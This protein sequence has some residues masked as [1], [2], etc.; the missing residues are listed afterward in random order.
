MQTGANNR[1][2][3][4][5]IAAFLLAV[6][7]TGVLLMGV[8]ASPADTVLSL[9]QGSLDSLKDF[10]YVLRSWV[11]LMLVTAGLLI[12]FSAGLWNIGVEGQIIIGAVCAT[13]ALRGL[14]DGSWPSWLVLCSASLAGVAGGMGWAWLAGLLKIRGGVNE[15]FGG[16]GLNFVANGLTMWLIFGP[17]KREGIGS[18]SGTEP[19]PEQFWLREWGTLHVSPAALVLAVAISLLVLVLI[20]RSRFGLKLR[21]AGLNARA[22]FRLGVPTTRIILLAFLLCGALS[23]L[24]GALQVTG[25]YHRLIPSISSGYGYLGLLVALVAGRRILWAAPVALFFAIVNVGAIEL[26]ITLQMDS[27]LSGVLLALIVL[28]V[29]LFNGVRQRMAGGWK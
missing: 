5:R 10:A 22:A 24:A 27:S 9:Y 18:M 4:F 21:A 25:V 19:F 13:W 1:A 12:T 6:L 7:T 15:I 23:G 14:Q 11:P 2:V 8:G 29:L 3:F 28:F 16:L 17:W 20:G 26:P